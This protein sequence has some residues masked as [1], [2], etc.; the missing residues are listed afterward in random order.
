[1]VAASRLRRAQERIQHGAAVRDRDAARA[2]QP[3]DARR[4]GAAPA[5]RRAA[6]RRRPAAR[7][8]C[9]SSP[10]TAACA[11]AST[12]TRSRARARSSSRTRRARWRSGWSA[13]AAATTS[14]AAASRSAT[15]RST[16]SQ[17]LQYSHAQAIAQAAVEAFTTG[18]VDSVYLVYNEFRSVMSQRSSSSGCCRFRGSEIE[19]DGRRR[20]PDRLPLRADAGGAVHDA[21]P[22]P[23]RGAGLPRAARVERRV[24][25]RADDGDGL[26]VAQRVGDDRPA[27]ALHEQGSPGGDH[28]RDY[29]SRVGRR[30]A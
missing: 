6:A 11:A 19:P 16:C 15:N 26:G 14:R 29:R 2:E 13:A 20:A 21:H 12:P 10:R 23:R 9:S 3:G 17:A 18:Q 25:R 4:F 30:S 5:A 22:A 27:H 1:M 8:C 7:R 24:L 28:A